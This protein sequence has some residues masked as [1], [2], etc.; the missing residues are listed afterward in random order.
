MLK[1]E[2]NGTQ[3]KDYYLFCLFYVN[4]VIII[5]LMILSVLFNQNTNLL[6]L[7]FTLSMPLSFITTNYLITGLIKIAAII[8]LFYI[9]KKI[10]EKFI[11]YYYSMKKLL[12]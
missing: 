6:I 9:V 4:I 2:T 3:T 5:I 12:R 10:I 8:N 11:N 1:K 7:L